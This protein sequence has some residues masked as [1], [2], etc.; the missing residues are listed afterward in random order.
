[1]QQRTTNAPGVG[2]SQ[3]LGLQII[4]TFARSQRQEMHK[5]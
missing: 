2:F 1:M 5:G 4:T 3:P